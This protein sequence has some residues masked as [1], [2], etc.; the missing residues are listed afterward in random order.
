MAEGALLNTIPFGR[1]Q[2]SQVNR[3]KVFFIYDFAFGEFQAQNNFFDELSRVQASI[4]NTGKVTLNTGEEVDLDSNGGLLALQI[5]TE[6][7]ESTKD[8]MSGLAKL[9]LKNEQKLW[10]LQ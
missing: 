3:E 8:S 9:G 10:T 5:Y 6:T 2:I 4:I 7:L 1:S